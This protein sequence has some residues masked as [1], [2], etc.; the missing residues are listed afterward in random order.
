M[1]ARIVRFDRESW[2][3]LYVAESI[4][5]RLLPLFVRGLRDYLLRLAE[6][7]GTLLHATKDPSGDLIR[8]LN[9][10]PRE[11]KQVAEAVSELLRIGY[12]SH[13]DGRLWISKFKEAQTARSKNAERQARFKAR[14]RSDDE[15]NPDSG[16]APEGVT[17]NGNGNV[18]EA[19]PKTL[20]RDETRRDETTAAKP[21]VVVAPQSPQKIPCPAK[22]KL[23]ADQRSQLEMNIGAPAWAVDEITA[24]FVG[25]YTG[26]PDDLRFEGDWRKC[27][28]VAVSS[29]W[30]NPKKRPQ[31][32]ESEPESVVTP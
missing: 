31:R 16:D 5:H 21:P 13:S 27:L 2:R 19:L 22:L 30:K 28:F 23:T 26:T 14:Q 7:D 29:T 1:E 10:L 11:R 6:D 32:H 20:Q 15:A 17:G 12:L 4:E 3:K 8:V 24:D 18:T 9:T 25:K